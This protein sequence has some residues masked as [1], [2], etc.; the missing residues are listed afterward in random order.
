VCQERDR[1]LALRFPEHLFPPDFSTRIHD[2]T[3]GNPLFM[4][5]LARFLRDRGVLAEHQGRWVMVGLLPDVEQELPE[6]VRSMVEKKIGQL[7]DDN[8]RLLVAAS[9]QGY[10][11]DSAVVATALGLNAADVEERLDLLG[12]VHGFVKLVNER[13]LADRTRTLRYRFVHVLYHNA[14]YASLQP[15]R[16]MSLSAAVAEALLRHQGTQRLAIASELALL[17][18][19]ARDFERASEHFLSAAEQAA[20]VSAHKEAVGLARRGLEA[21]MMLPETPERMQ[22]EL[23]LQTMLGPALMSTLG[24][25]APEVEAVYTRA[26]DLCQQLGDT[27]W[28]FAAMWG[29]NQYWLARGDYRTARESA[30]QLLVSAQRLQDPALLM[31]AHGALANVCWLSGNFEAVRTHAEQAIAIYV[32]QQHHSLRSLYSG[33]DP[34]VAQ[35]SGP[36][37]SLWLLGYPDQALQRCHEGLTLAREL[38]HTPSVVFALIFAAMVH[39]HRRESQH[40]RRHAEAAIALA[41]EQELAQWLP[42]GT[43]LRGWALVEQGETDEGIAQ[44]RKA[45]AGW[46]AVRGRALSPY[47]LAL[48]ADA[49]ARTGQAGKAGAALAEALAITEETHEGYMEAELYRLKGEVEVEPREVE[50]CLQRAIEIAKRQNAKSFELRAVVRLNRLY[51]QQGSQAEGRRMLASTYGW[52]TE[53]FDTVDLKEAAALLKDVDDRVMRRG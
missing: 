28:L 38:A 33:R 26:R 21:L 13:D 31:M 46:R 52:F 8:R 45:I 14:L 44:L 11:F 50:S 25:G 9:V 22:R 18:E 49:Y 34:G 43:A 35:R 10:E 30:D 20:H 36:A 17:F 12:R 1:Y 3:E 47:F 32:P 40:T 4:A 39:Q 19:A 2:R 48:L 41:S 15:T 5:D 27:P 42:W 7:G 53:G 37:V 23:R 16:K 51:Q 29:Q 24:Y 6:S